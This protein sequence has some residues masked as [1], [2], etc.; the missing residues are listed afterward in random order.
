MDAEAARCIASRCGL[1]RVRRLQEAV[2]NRKL[3]LKKMLGSEKPSDVATKPKSAAEISE[4]LS[5]IGDTLHRKTNKCQPHVCIESC[6]PCLSKMAGAAKK[7][8]E[9]VGSTPRG[10]TIGTG[11]EM[12]ELEDSSD[13]DADLVEC[14]DEDS[15]DDEDESLG[16]LVRR[17]QKEAR[18][19]V[20][21]SVGKM[22]EKED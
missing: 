7:E 12:G 22:R 1:G 16:G 8:G 20:P 11:R 19:E 14:H 5:R 21:A 3:K 6:E 18:Q 10:T 2:E 15:S 13:E 4:Q 9:R 17:Y